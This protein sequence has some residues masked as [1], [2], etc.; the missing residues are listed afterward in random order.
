MARRIEAGEASIPQTPAYTIPE[1]QAGKHLLAREAGDNL[2][3][4]LGMD[5]LEMAAF[6]EEKVLIEMAEMPTDSGQVG[7]P[8]AVAPDTQWVIGG[9]RALIKRKFVEVLAR[10]RTDN[11]KQYQNLQNPAA[12][13]PVPKTSLSYPFSVIEDTPKG[14]SWLK[15]LLTNSQ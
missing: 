10:A 14:R 4:V 5:E 2:L 1:I 12:S 13:R 9:Q 7:V 15:E 8:L 6:M 3:D 11:Y